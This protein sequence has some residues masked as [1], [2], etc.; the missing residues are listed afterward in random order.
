MSPDYLFNLD[1]FGAVLATWSLRFVLYVLPLMFAFKYVADQFW[2]DA[3]S[4]K[5]A[6][7][8]PGPKEFL[9]LGNGLQFWFSGKGER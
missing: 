3:R 1:T 2:R 7:S 8:L 5:A 6:S 9:R 4:V